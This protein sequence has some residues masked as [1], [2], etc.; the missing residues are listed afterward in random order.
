LL[1]LAPLGAFLGEFLAGFGLLPY[2]V[3]F[4][5]S[6]ASMLILPWMVA[7][8][9]LTLPRMKIVFSGL[10]FVGALAFQSLLL[11][12]L[13]P[14]GATSEMMGL[15]HRFRWE[16]SVDDLRSVA[17]Q[18]RSRFESGTL[19]VSE[20][21]AEDYYLANESAKRIPDAELPDSLR[22]RF[23]RVFIHQDPI[24]QE[25]QILFA[26]DRIRGIVCDNRRVAHGFFEY[27]MAEG[28][29]AYR[30]QRL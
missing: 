2:G 16:F 30:Y 9:F 13:V 7:A 28:V 6:A 21:G 10:L 24:K 20:G 11:Y 29:H 23:Q 17:D 5:A 15:A 4:V 1:T 25:I 27:S 14:P 26:L 12:A 8:L 22:G 3:G 19:E 18:L